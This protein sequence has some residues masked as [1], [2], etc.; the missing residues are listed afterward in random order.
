MNNAV[1][2]RIQR[3]VA[4]VFSLPV[5]GITT[6]SSPDTMEMWDSLQHLNLVLAIE[7][8]F[9]VVFTPEQIEEMLSVELIVAL[10]EEKL[11]GKGTRL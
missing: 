9:D 3:I 6:D 8:E 7:Q 1:F 5:D 10:L 11:P 4:D 2:A